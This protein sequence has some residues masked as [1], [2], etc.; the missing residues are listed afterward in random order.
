VS[1]PVIKARPTFYRGV[2]MRSRLEADYASALDRAE[3]PW[4]YEPCC[5]GGPAGQWLPDFRTDDEYVELKP[6]GPLFAD[7]WPGRR[8]LDAT[9]VLDA[10]VV[11][12]NK[13][14]RRMTVVWDSE[15]DAGLRLVFWSYGLDVEAAPLELS[16]RRTWPRWRAWMPGLHWGGLGIG[17]EWPHDEAGS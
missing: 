5:F 16:R 2:L 6:A 12:V 10:R 15:P 17:L 14:L 8:A 4:E 13:M 3:Y 7:P 1:A 11:A 9:D